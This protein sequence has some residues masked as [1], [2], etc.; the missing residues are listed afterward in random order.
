MV[1]AF[2]S[3]VVRNPH[4]MGG[5]RLGGWDLARVQ[6]QIPVNKNNIEKNLQTANYKGNIIAIVEK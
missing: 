1:C 4:K 5:L 6:F 3:P 2:T